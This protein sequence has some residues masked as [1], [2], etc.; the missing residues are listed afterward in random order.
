M[1]APK[2]Y[3]VRGMYGEVIA[4]SFRPETLAD[5]SIGRSVTHRY[6]KNTKQLAAAMLQSGSS[7][8]LIDAAWRMAVKQGA[9]DPSHTFVYGDPLDV[10]TVEYAKQE[11]VQLDYYIGQLVNNPNS[12]FYIYG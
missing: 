1:T 7:K 6:I 5:A 8:K 10:Q 3:I 9:V 11:S 2:L 4:A 12:Q